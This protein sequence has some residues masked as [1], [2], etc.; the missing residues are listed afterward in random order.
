L[1][2]VENGG[3]VNMPDTGEHREIQQRV[4]A[5]EAEVIREEKRLDQKLK[6]DLSSKKRAPGHGKSKPKK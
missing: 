1:S 3:Q 6:A 5:N 4:N 2:L